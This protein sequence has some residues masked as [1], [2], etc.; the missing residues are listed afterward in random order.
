MFSTSNTLFQIT[1]WYLVIVNVVTFFLYGIDKFKAK[2]AKWRIPESVLL[3]MAAIGGSIGAWLGM[4][5]WRHKTQHN[6]FRYGI[7]AI[8]ILQAAVL[9]FYILNT[10]G[11]SCFTGKVK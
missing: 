4:R 8:L 2:H 6:K 5:I 1:F 11:Y 9:Y 7:P 10:D 3:G